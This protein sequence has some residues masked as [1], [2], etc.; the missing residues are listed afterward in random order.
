MRTWFSRS[1]MQTPTHRKNTWMKSTHIWLKRLLDEHT[2]QSFPRNIEF[3]RRLK[4]TV[5]TTIWEGR[6][7]TSRASNAGLNLSRTTT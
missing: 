7:G 4:R 6:H 5:Q 2:L 3:S 1:F